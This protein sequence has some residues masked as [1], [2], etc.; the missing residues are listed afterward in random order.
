MSAVVC[1][2]G[3][4]V[5]TNLRV[6]ADGQR[7]TNGEKAPIGG[8][9]RYRAVC[10][11]C[12]Y[13]DVEDAATALGL[14]GQV[15]IASPLADAM[16]LIFPAGPAR[17]SVSDGGRLVYIAGAGVTGRATRDSLLV[18]VNTS[19]LYFFRFFYFSPTIK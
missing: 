7:A 1:A 12:F 19:A 15:A 4:Q 10:P 3:R 17:M 13:G 11:R 9:D 5:S 18:L 16:S 14:F 2:C 8:N 6:D